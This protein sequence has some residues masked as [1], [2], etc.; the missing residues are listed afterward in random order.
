MVVLAFVAGFGVPLYVL[1]WLF[2]PLDEEDESIGARAVQDARGIAIGIALMT[3]V[4]LGLFVLTALGISWAGSFSTAVLVGGAGLVLVWRDASPAERAFLHERYGPLI[5]HLSTSGRSRRLLLGRVVAALAMLGG[6]LALLL[7]HGRL[8]LAS[9]RP[10]SGLVLVVAAAVV[11]LGPWWFRVAKDLVGERQARARA[12]ER[13]EM[14]LRLHDSVLQTLALIQRRAEQ[15]SEVVKLARRQER[16]L[17]AWL[18]DSRAGAAQPAEGPGSGSTLDGEG[19]RVDTFAAAV[20][21][22]EQD[23]EAVHGVVVETVV[24]GDCRLDAELRALVSA[25]SEA[26]VNAA[27]WSGCP[28]ISVFAEVDGSAVSVFVRDT[29][30]GFE[31]AEVPPDRRGLSDSIKGRMARIGGRATIRTAPGEGTEIA[32]VLPLAR[33]RGSGSRAS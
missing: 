32:L 23:V 28:V 22:I 17:R 7:E 8:G 16:E 31:P 18:F 11:L 6:G 30:V 25:A 2:L 14:A 12:E 21:G 24:V 9:L 3:I 10:L 19:R 20:H 4:G 27:K 26:T 5:D 1:A 13:E 33:E 15:P 29:G